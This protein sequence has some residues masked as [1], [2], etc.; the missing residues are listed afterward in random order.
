[1]VAFVRPKMIAYERTKIVALARIDMVAFERPKI[2][3][4]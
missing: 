1:M 3:S 2:V 4:S